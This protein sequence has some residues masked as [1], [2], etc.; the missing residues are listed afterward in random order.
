MFFADVI[1]A[2]NHST[3]SHHEVLQWEVEAVKVSILPEVQV[4]CESWSVHTGL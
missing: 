3:G 2:D 4:L 1:L